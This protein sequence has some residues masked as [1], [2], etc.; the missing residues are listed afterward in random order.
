MVTIQCNQCGAGFE[1]EPLI[2][3]GREL[4]R[5]NFCD[6][7]CRDQEARQA[8]SDREAMV[9]MQ[10]D[11]WERICPPLYRDTDMSRIP[12]AFQAIVTGW[13]FG[14]TGLGFTGEAGK[15][16]T[17]AAFLILKAQHFAGRRVCAA[18]ATK[19][20]SW[21]QNRFSDDPERKAAAFAG[22]RDL[23]AAKVVLIDD[24]GKSKMTET[25]EQEFFD[26]LEHRTSHC[27][28]T[29]WTANA[30]AAELRKM[31]SPDRGDPIMRRLKEFSEI[32]KSK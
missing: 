8:A 18:S 16:K 32:V 3:H 4:F 29:I 14:P 27:L 17:R 24:L 5:P 25:V 22:L 28:P 1:H 23:R 15:C 20:G 6:A 9:G 2:L 10:N 26:I 31:M 13:K 7:C 11:E 12:A 30:G 21:A 19:M